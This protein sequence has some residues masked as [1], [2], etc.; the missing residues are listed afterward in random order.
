MKLNRICLSILSFITFAKSECTESAGEV[1]NFS[2]NYGLSNQFFLFEVPCESTDGL[3]FTIFF[4]NNTES[5][6]ILRLYE[7]IPYNDQI[8]LSNDPEYPVYPQVSVKQL[9][10]ILGPRS[11]LNSVVYMPDSLNPT[12]DQW[13]REPATIILNK[14]SKVVFKYSPSKVSIIHSSP[15]SITTETIFDISTWKIKP[16][17]FEFLA[18]YGQLELSQVNITC[19]SD[20]KNNGTIDENEEDVN[21]NEDTSVNYN[22]V[23]F[24]VYSG[25]GNLLQ[26]PSPRYSIKKAAKIDFPIESSS[27]TSSDSMSETSTDSSSQTSS[28]SVSETS[29]DSISETSS[30]SSSQTSSDSI[31]ETSKTSSEFDEYN[32]NEYYDYP[33]KTS[34][35]N[36]NEYYDSLSTE[37]SKTVSDLPDGLKSLTIDDTDTDTDMANKTTNKTSNDLPDGSKSL[38]IDDTDADI[39]NKTSNDLPDGSKSLTIDDTD[40]DTDMA[41]KT[42]NDLPDGS[43]SLTI[44][45]TDTD[46]ANK[47]SNDLPDGSKSLT[48][49]DTDTDMANKTVNDLSDGSKSMTADDVESE[50]FEKTA[51]KDSKFTSSEPIINKFSSNESIVKTSSIKSEDILKTIPT[52]SKAIS[53]PDLR[54]TYTSNNSESVNEGEDKN[55]SISNTRTKTNTELDIGSGNLDKM[56]SVDKIQDNTGTTNLSSTFISNKHTTIKA[57]TA[58]KTQGTPNTTSKPTVNVTSTTSASISSTI[59]AT[60]KKKDLSV[61]DIPKPLKPLDIPRVRMKNS[62]K[63]MHAYQVALDAYKRFKYENDM[64]IRRY[65][66]LEYMVV[67]KNPCMVN[68][69]TYLQHYMKTKSLRKIAVTLIQAYEKMCKSIR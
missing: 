29:S 9:D 66:G 3:E 25:V 30:D 28:D 7:E 20:C 37:S 31:S 58:T 55:S 8:N 46:M 26:P 33:P 32:E 21:L 22:S 57:S 54:S 35:N 47:T 4:K 63:G 16:V 48:I 62:K 12:D 36:E 50:K 2:D 68:L 64:L 49:D 67:R 5:D 13:V 42:V 14:N 34:E 11:S 23:D 65:G 6:V 18:W 1:I 27:E 53:T 15:I 40:T 45:D 69:V 52:E 41:N 61:G 44:D 39:A 51:D 17:Y 43:K 10:L 38:R 60:N 59:K 56:D 24:N 19:S